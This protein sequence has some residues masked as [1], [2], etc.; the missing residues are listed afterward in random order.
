MSANKQIGY[1]QQVRC[2]L[3]QAYTCKQTASYSLQPTIVL[4]SMLIQAWLRTFILTIMVGRSA[5]LTHSFTSVLSTGEGVVGR[6][7]CHD[8][9]IGEF[10]VR[11]SVCLSPRES[12]QNG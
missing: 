8:K 7:M 1:D 6:R 5:L 2:S 11:R 9:S 12:C 10:V 3:R 4:L